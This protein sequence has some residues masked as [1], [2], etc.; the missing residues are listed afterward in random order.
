L[1][2]LLQ[3]IKGLTFLGTHGTFV[4]LQDAEK[5]MGGFH[6]ISADV[7]ASYLLMT[8]SIF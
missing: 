1:R 3:N 2:L 8:V 5:V 4:C 7:P 6:E